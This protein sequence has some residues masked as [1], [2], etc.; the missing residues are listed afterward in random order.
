MGERDIVSEEEGGEAAVE[1][2]AVLKKEVF[3][4]AH[5]DLLERAVEAL[6]TF[7]LGERGRMKKCSGLRW[8]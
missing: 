6:I 8:R 3:V 7:C 1:G 4:E 5:K 2:V